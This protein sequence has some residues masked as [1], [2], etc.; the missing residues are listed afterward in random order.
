MTMSILQTK[1]LRHKEIKQLAIS[2]TA[3][4]WKSQDLHPSNLAPESSS[5]VQGLCWECPLASPPPDSMRQALL[6]TA[7]G[8]SFLKPKRSPLDDADSF[9][10]LGSMS[11]EFLLGTARAAS[12]YAVPMSWTV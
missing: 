2:H 4:K 12:E 9:R 10:V 7:A 6:Y 8:E 11:Q 5:C 1:K 3:R